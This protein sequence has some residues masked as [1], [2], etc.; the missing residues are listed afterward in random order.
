MS[1]ATSVSLDGGREL[2]GKE[3]RKERPFLFYFLLGM[4]DE[5]R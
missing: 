4:I 3:E 1:F 5:D 2:R